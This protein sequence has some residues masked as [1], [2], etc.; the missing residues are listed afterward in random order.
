MLKGI[1]TALKNYEDRNTSRLL[2]NEKHLAYVQANLTE[3]IVGRRVQ[4]EGS[5]KESQKIGKYFQASSY[6]VIESKKKDLPLSIKV[7]GRK[8]SLTEIEEDNIKRLETI[9]EYLIETEQKRVAKKIAS[10]TPTEALNIKNNPHSLYLDNLVTFEVAE[11]IARKTGTSDRPGRLNAAV[12][13]LLDRYY[14]NGCTFI[15]LPSLV[16]DM[17][18]LLTTDVDETELQA[19]LNKKIAVINDEQQVFIPKIFYLREKTLAMVR[20]NRPSMICHEDDNL[21]GLLSHMYTILTGAAGTGKTTQL[22]AVKAYLEEQG[23]KVALTA[24]TGKAASVLGDGATT[25]HKLLGYGYG[26]FSVKKVSQDV[27]IVDEAS[28][29]DWYTAHTLYKAA[30]EGRV[31][32]SGDPNQLPPV[33]GGSVFAELIPILPNVKLEKVHR[34][35]GGAANIQV[36]QRASVYDLLSATTT[37]A[38]S[39]TRKGESFQVLTPVLGTVIGT[40]NLNRI[41]QGKLNPDGRK[42]TEKYRLGDRVIVTKNCYDKEV[43]AYNGQVGYIIDAEENG[44]QLIVKLDNNEVLPFSDDEIELAYSLTV[45]K[46]QGSQFDKVIFVAPKSQCGEFLDEKMMYTGNTRGRIATYC[47]VC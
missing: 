29:M 43:P 45:H 8:H 16:A 23:Y 13:E 41:L 30:G 17:L 39:L 19:V 5:W 31:I 15:P 7:F 24:M 33:K 28:M 2:I 40:F 42:A 46:A 4:L 6:K 10:L 3:I 25:L 14:N 32:L 21:D 36:I 20:A 44:E 26:G 9:L 47:L 35:V 1:V 38:L 27:I 18:A 34:F 12:S 22:R 11:S 37:L